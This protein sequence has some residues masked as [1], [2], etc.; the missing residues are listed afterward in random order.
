[1]IFLTSC[2]VIN[3]GSLLK[4]PIFENEEYEIYNTLKNSIYSNSSLFLDIDKSKKSAITFLNNKN[5]AVLFYTTKEKNNLKMALFNKIN[6][7]WKYVLEM[8]LGNAKLLDVLTTKIK[9]KNSEFLIVG[10]KK[11]KEKVYTIYNFDGKSINKIFSNTYNYMCLFDKQNG[12]DKTLITLVKCVTLPKIKENKN[13]ELTE[14]VEKEINFYEEHLKKYKENSDISKKNVLD[15][16]MFL[17]ISLSENK[18]KIT[19]CIKKI[20]NTSESLVYEIFDTKTL[21]APALFLSFYSN[22]SD[23]FFKRQFA[24]YYKE[25]SFHILDNFTGCSAYSIPFLDIEKNGKLK[26]LESSNMI[27]YQHKNLNPNYSDYSPNKP[28]FA[29][30]HDIPNIPNRETNKIPHKS[31]HIKNIKLMQEYAYIN[32][33]HKYGI[34]F[35]KDWDPKDFTAKYKNENQDIDFFLWDGSLEKDSQKF[36]SISVDYI[37]NKNKKDN[38]YFVLTQKNNLIYYANIYE[39]SNI[40]NPKYKLTRK[41]L[42]ELFFTI[43]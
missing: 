32:F 18:I 29:I 41:K 28:Y 11:N 10:I 21:N 43:D 8:P 6:S 3:D 31:N 42:E 30:L 13:I 2:S 26:L 9:G 1:M 5:S 23:D 22:N 38:D 35:P 40:N 7:T 24:L 20:I 15:E 33:N 39:N 14:N 34:K 27:G 17:F 25:N 19:D 16:T 36:L 4:A 37:S 12:E